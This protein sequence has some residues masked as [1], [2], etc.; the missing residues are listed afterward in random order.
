M[1]VVVTGGAG[2][3]GSAVCRQLVQG[4]NAEVMNVDK[5]TYAS[6][7]GS[8]EAL[9]GHPNYDFERLDICDR[10]G[11]DRIFA[12]FEPDAVIHLAA[13]SHVDRSI[14]GPSAF[15]ASNIVGSYTLLEAARAYHS[16]LADDRRDRFRFVH[17]ST[18]EVYGSLGETGL[19]VEETPYRPSSPYSASKA[20]SDHL[21]HAWYKTYGLPVIVTNCSNNYGPYQFPEKLI[22]LM[23]LNAID[24]KPL[25]VYGAG[26][27]IRDW[28]FVEDHAEGLIRALTHGRPGESYNFG[29]NCERSNL[30]VVKLIG[31]YYD[32]IET[33]TSPTSSLITHV[34]DRPGHDLRYAIDASKAHRELG[35]GPRR[36][37]EEGLRS[38]VEW[39]LA[40]RSW[41]A[42]VRSGIYDGRRLG[43]LRA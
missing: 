6:N 30:D 35:W 43:L 4:H 31:R 29:G 37:F 23:I 39:Y 7:L 24:H 19:F 11:L 14:S 21:A 16:N 3:I 15:I 41:W 22:P 13:E 33:P 38:T 1:R 9:A 28:L 36:T 32:E 34:E 17:V 42:S 10:K 2:F 20:A 26:S 5:L 8:L 27:N 25:P 40:N 18:D 12:T